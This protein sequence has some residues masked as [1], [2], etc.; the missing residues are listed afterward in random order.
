[1]AVYTDITED[2]L[3]NFLTQYDVGSLTSYKG[4]AEGVENSNFLL[5]TTKDPLILTLYEKRVEKS[6]LP[7]F[8]GLMQHLAAK[9]LSCP[10]PLP[11]KDGELLGELS[12]RPAAL[13]S[14]L[15]GMWL[16]KPEAKHCREVGKALAAMH[17]AGEG[18]EIK[19]P[20]ALSVEG[21]K[22]LW[23]KSEDRADEVEKGLKDEIRPEIDYLAAHWPKDLPAGVIHADLF[24]DNVFFLGDELSGLIDFYFACNDLL[25]YD[26]SICLNAWCFE[27]DG[28]YNVTKGKALLEGYQSVRPLS[29]AELEALPLLAR[30]SALRFFLT[31]LY[32][33]LTTPEGAL[34]VKKDP[35]EYLRKLRFHRSIATVAEY[36]LAGE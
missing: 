14:F 5:H 28:A 24:Q 23:E 35:L 9:G 25:A 18:F 33:W 13:I 30:G 17:L 34:V 16:R 36:G 27:K 32:D 8:L 21:W 26:V 1:M 22:V 3:R 6:D 7:F 19:R 4:I 11:R 10:L 15:E 31:R 20:N 12:G 2:D 29:E